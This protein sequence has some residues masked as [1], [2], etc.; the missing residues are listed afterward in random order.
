MENDPNKT[1]LV[2]WCK[3]EDLKGIFSPME[4]TDDLVCDTILLSFYE[5]KENGRLRMGS[6]KC[7]F[8]NRGHGLMTMINFPLLGHNP[9]MGFFRKLAS[10][11]K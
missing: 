1:W 10:K 11:Q 8:W 3:V 7:V 9:S 2:A 5:M 6:N 4:Y